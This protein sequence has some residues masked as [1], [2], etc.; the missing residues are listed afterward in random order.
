MKLVN[1]EYGKA[2]ELEKRLRDS[3]DVDEW[4]DIV[5]RMRKMVYR[6]GASHSA[7]VHDG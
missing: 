4:L 6:H 7:A 1:D 5:H 2:K 3:T